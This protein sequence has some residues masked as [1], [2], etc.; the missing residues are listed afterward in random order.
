M[1]P[2]LKQLCKCVFVIVD[3]K[4]IY[5]TGART[6]GIFTISP[7][8]ATTPFD[9]YCNMTAG[10]WTVVQRQTHGDVN[11]TR[12]YTDYV[13]GFGD[14]SGDHWLGLERIHLL[15]SRPRYTSA[16]RISAEFYNG[17]WGY[18]QYANVSV[19][20]SNSGYMLHVTRTHQDVSTLHLSRGLEHGPIF[21]LY[22]NDGRA[23]STIDHDLTGFCFGPRSGGGGWWY[24]GCSYIYINAH[25]GVQA[26]GGITLDYD[27]TYFTN[28]VMMVKRN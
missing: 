21:G 18:E 25:Y 19:A 1:W 7:K 3:C 9:V 2:I 23:F 27:Y 15:T 4:A 5:D 13:N 24:F 28:P 8:G 10:G 14:V 11:F 22:H 20:D 6:D 26:P 16:V 17:N 12:R